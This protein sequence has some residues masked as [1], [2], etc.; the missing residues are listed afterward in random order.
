MPYV[1]TITGHFS[2]FS[3]PNLVEVRMPLLQQVN[4]F[5]VL[6]DLP[7]LQRVDFGK[8]RTIGGSVGLT[9]LPKLNQQP[10]SQ[11]INAS[12]EPDGSRPALSE[13]PIFIVQSTNISVLDDGGSNVPWG[14]FHR[15]VKIVSNPSL[16]NISFQGFQKSLASIDIAR[17]HPNLLVDFE[18]LETVVNISIADVA[19]VRMPN[20]VSVGGDL[21]VTNCGMN[22]LS[23]K[24]LNKTDDGIYIRQNPK[25]QKIEFDQLRTVGVNYWSLSHTGNLK[26]EDNPSLTNLDGFPNL[27]S[28]R[29]A[30]VLTGNFT[31]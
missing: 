26:I 21:R 2:V 19:D 10:F 29:D 6:T 7:E 8:L 4:A 24:S 3:S 28:V 31:R 18:A 1:Q 23:L 22:T 9:N 14:K 13:L 30:V 15:Y 25:L 5:F 16:K 17:N 11:E 20:L 12:L 27:W